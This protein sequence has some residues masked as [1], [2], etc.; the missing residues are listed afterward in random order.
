MKTFEELQQ[1]ASEIGVGNLKTYGPNALPKWRNKKF[2]LY[3][4]GT[5]NCNIGFYNLKDLETYLV[6]MKEFLGK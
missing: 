5:D 1:M 3:E 2:F 4:P 6:K